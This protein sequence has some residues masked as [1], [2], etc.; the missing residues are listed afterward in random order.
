MF[1]DPADRLGQTLQSQISLTRRRPIHQ[2]Q[3]PVCSPRI[4]L[5]APSPWFPQVLIGQ[6]AFLDRFRGR[7]GQNAGQRDRI[8][9]RLIRA[10]SLMRQHAVRRVSQENDRTLAALK[11]YVEAQATQRQ[12]G[13]RSAKPLI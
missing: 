1:V 9:N 6:Q 11:R 12:S 13:D 2:M 10:L 5:H 8:L 7:L 4:L 3:L